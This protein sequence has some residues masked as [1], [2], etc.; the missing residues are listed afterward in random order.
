MKKIC[1]S[2]TVI[3]VLLA[4]V[5]PAHAAYTNIYLSGFQDI[6][7]Q[8]KLTGEIYY[9]MGGTHSY[10]Y[11]VDPSTDMPVPA[12]YYVEKFSIAGNLPLLQVAWLMDSYAYSKSGAFTGFTA[13]QTGTIVQLAIYDAIGKPVAVVPGYESLF[14]KKDEIEASMPLT[15][16]DLAYLSAKY[17][18]LDIYNNSDKTT[19]FQDLLTPVPIPAGVWLLGSGLIGLV[20]L[21]KRQ[22]PAKTT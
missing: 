14:A 13:V 6:D 3:V 17:A 21:R 8:N 19:A 4:L 1:I 18:R 15:L 11:C 7:W 16:S 9:D 10:S 2:F 22:G 20:C 5:L 12:S